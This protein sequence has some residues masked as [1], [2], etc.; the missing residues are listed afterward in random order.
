MV[1]GYQIYCGAFLFFIDISLFQQRMKPQYNLTS[2][3]F[4]ETARVKTM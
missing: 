4:S 3:L 2:D 1:L